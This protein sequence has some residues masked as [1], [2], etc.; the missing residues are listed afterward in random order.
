MEITLSIPV[1]PKKGNVEIAKV[2]RDLADAFD[3]PATSP[4]T[5]IQTVKEVV[6]EELPTDAPIEYTFDQITNQFKDYAAQYGR[7]AAVKILNTFKVKKV[8]DI[9][10]EAYPNVMKALGA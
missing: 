10:P 5:K 6:T 4:V 1:N 7:E 8:A 2:L 9:K 3:L